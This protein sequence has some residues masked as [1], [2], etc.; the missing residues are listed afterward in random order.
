M[1]HLAS[2]APPLVCTAA[3]RGRLHLSAGPDGG[4]VPG[5]AERLHPALTGAHAGG[6]PPEGRAP[7]GGGHEPVKAWPVHLWTPVPVC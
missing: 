1:R 4:Q 7:P 6:G 3:D 2:P 5:A